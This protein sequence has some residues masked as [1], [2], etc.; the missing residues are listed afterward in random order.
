MTDE[1][2]SNVVSLADRR[3]AMTSE[4]APSTVTYQMPSADNREQ[5][6]NDFIALLRTDDGRWVTT[7]EG[8][9]NGLLALT[10]DQSEWLGMALIQNALEIRMREQ[11]R[12]TDKKPEP[13]NG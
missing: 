7:L 13:D 10:A 2:H 8:P 1:R 6:T 11:G 5:L 3:A 12:W 9:T 4:S